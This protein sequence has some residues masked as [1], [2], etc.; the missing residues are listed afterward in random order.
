MTRLVLQRPKATSN[1]ILAL[2]IASV[3]AAVASLLSVALLKAKTLVEVRAPEQNSWLASMPPVRK[4]CVKQYLRSPERFEASMR[5]ALVLGTGLSVALFHAALTPLPSSLRLALAVVAPATIYA[6]TYE[7]TRRLTQGSSASRG[8]WLLGLL[9][10]LRKHPAAATAEPPV[11]DLGD[12]RLLVSGQVTL[13]ELSQYLGTA[14]LAPQ[15]VLSLG[16]YIVS[17]FGGVPPS[18]A[19]FT[20]DFLQFVVAERTTNHVTR[21]ELTRLVLD[22]A[23][24]GSPLSVAAPSPTTER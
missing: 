16:D 22:T 8:A 11:L 1:Y 23:Q 18:G 21:V 17:R 19:T 13:V 3:P 6:L 2:I 4:R 5:V 14:I 15:S 12:G 7:V 10:G 9:C 20:L 24:P